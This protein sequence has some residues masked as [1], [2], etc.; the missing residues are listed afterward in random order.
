MCFY[1]IRYK[2]YSMPTE[3]DRF[4]EIDDDGPKAGTNAD[5]ILSFLRDNPDK[6]FT[7]GE[8]AER[9]GVKTGSV[10]PTLVRLR[11]KGRVEHR[12]RY[13]RV[14]DRERSGGASIGLSSST[15]AARENGEDGGG[16][17]RDGWR[18]HAVDPRESRD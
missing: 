4:K 18:E 1:Y 2:Q 12:G 7:R 13:W 3:A 17:D 10:G 8:I 16:F 11:D 15:A 9:A 6:A 5:E 14:S